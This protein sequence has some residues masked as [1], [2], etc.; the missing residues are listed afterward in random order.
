MNMFKSVKAT[1]V[2]EYLAQVPPERQEIIN[3]IHKLIKDTVPAL[4][5]HF[6]YNMLG[7]GSFKYKDYKK[8][9][10]DWPVIA[11]ANQ[12]N[13]VSLYV[14]AV[15]D[16]EYLAEKHKDELGKVNVGRSCIRFK[17]IEDLY[18]ENVKK[19][20]KLAE[21]NPGIVEAKA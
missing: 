4:K 7:Y 11:L 6:A 17:K 16:G 5:P 10:I 21:K 13:Y 12:K 3:S 15:K 1:T 20:L 18:L 14:C 19:V 9:D 2:E 8:R